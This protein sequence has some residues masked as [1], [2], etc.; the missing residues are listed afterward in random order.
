[1]GRIFVLVP[2]VLL[3]SSSLALPGGRVAKEE[4]ESSDDDT[5]ASR[6][7]VKT[8]DDDVPILEVTTTEC[9]VGGTCRM[10]K[11]NDR[12]GDRTKRSKR[13]AAE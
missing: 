8:A 1:M 7:V 6:L 9:S 2:V 3:L 13:D 4:E 11:P 10:T 12:C 5:T